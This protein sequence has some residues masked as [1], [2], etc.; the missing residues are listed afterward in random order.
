MHLDAE[1]LSTPPHAGSSIY[2]LS[3]RQE[4]ARKIPSKVPSL[5]KRLNNIN[6]EVLSTGWAC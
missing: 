2:T 4:T 3:S 1:I 5:R 6:I